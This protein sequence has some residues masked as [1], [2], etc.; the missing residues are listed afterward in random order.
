MSYYHYHLG[1]V[2]RATA[3]LTPTEVGVFCLMRDYYLTTE[4]PIPQ[5][6][7]YRVARA[8]TR[9]E[10]AAVDRVLGEAFRFSRGSYACTALDELIAETAK[11]ISNKKS[12]G[13]AGGKAKAEKTLKNQGTSLAGASDVPEHS[14]SKTLANQNPKPIKPSS[15]NLNHTP[16]PP[17]SAAELAAQVAASGVC[18]SPDDI[19]GWISQGLLPA[20]I[21]E[22]VAITSR[23]GK[24]RPYLLGVLRNRLSDPPRPVSARVTRAEV[25]RLARPGESYDEAFRRITSARV[26]H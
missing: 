12:A 23:A 25:E 22:A 2:C 16:Q 1:D 6:S 20:D 5:A 18:V 4:R 7:V 26:T 15:I 10:R 13:A 21:L 24:S 19:E 3:H 11:K 17:S 8:R 9:A 14:P